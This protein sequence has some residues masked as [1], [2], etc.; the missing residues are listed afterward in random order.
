MYSLIH[1]EVEHLQRLV[2]DVRLLS[3]ADAGELSL[4]RWAV[5]SS[6]LVERTGLAYTVQIEEQGLALPAY[7]PQSQRSELE[8]PG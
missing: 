7:Y 2:E 8:F 6:P 1:G 4:N 5:D 3:L